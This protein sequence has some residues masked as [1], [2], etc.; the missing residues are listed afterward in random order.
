M[1][2]SSSLH[3]YLLQSPLLVLVETHLIS[4]STSSSP[5]R[6]HQRH[7]PLIRPTCLSPR[8]QQPFSL[9]G[10]DLAPWCC[11]HLAPFL[12]PLLCLA[13]LRLTTLSSPFV[14]PWTNRVL[15]LFIFGRVGFEPVA[16]PRASLYWFLMAVLCDFCLIV[17]FLLSNCTKFLGWIVYR[18]WYVLCCC[19]VN[20]YLGFGMLV[21]CIIVRQGLAF[22][23]LVPIGTNDARVTILILSIFVWPVGIFV[24][25]FWCVLLVALPNVWLLPSCSVVICDWFGM[26]EFTQGLNYEI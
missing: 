20:P 18:Y 5:F 19:W 6:W 26:M 14:L 21:D 10:H 1:E 7:Q 3:A 16:E 17:V 13:E 24:I 8:R 12:L 9:K 2:P 4:L 11:S 23:T 25:G 22:G 15:S